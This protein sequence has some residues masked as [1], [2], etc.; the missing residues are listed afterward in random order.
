MPRN[1]F[2]AGYSVVIRTEVVPASVFSRS[3]MAHTWQAYIYKHISTKC[4]RC[5]HNK[6]P[7]LQMRWQILEHCT[8]PS[9]WGDLLE[10][11]TNIYLAYVPAL[12]FL[13][14]F[15]SVNTYI[16]NQWEGHMIWVQHPTLLDKCQSLPIPFFNSNLKKNFPSMLTIL[17]QQVPEVWNYGCKHNVEERKGGVKFLYLE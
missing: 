9:G 6:I 3:F 13:L 5:S 12:V 11:S 7:S 14:Y 4:N 2:V 16:K 15:T 1:R 10:K 17:F 8:I